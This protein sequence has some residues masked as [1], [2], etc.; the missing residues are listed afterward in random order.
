MSKVRCFRRSAHVDW[1]NANASDESRDVL[2]MT[3]VRTIASVAGMP[4]LSRVR[5]RTDDSEN[6]AT[7]QVD[8]RPDL[9]VVDKGDQH[10]DRSEAKMPDSDRTF[11]DDRD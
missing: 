7:A 2:V 3:L 8:D 1:R 10:T 9:L 5:R 6:G 11:V 4:A